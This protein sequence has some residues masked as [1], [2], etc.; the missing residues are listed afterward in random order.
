MIELEKQKIKKIIDIKCIKEW[1]RKLIDFSKIEIEEMKNSL[2]EIFIPLMRYDV[3]EIST[4]QEYLTNNA[5]DKKLT[6]LIKGLYHNNEQEFFGLF[7]EE[8]HYK[9]FLKN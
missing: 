6:N 4:I 9:D 7:F 8:G 3:L 1:L 5:K 2:K